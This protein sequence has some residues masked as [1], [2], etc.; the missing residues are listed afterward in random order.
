MLTLKDLKT[1]TE[2]KELKQ[3]IHENRRE[4]HKSVITLRSDNIYFK[5]DCTEETKK[6]IK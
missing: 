5:T 4:N 1:H 3:I 2:W 6:G